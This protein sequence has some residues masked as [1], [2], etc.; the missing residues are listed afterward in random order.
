MAPRTVIGMCAGIGGLE[1]GVA[2]VLPTIPICF[3]EQDPLCTSVLARHWPDTPIWSDLETFDGLAWRGAVDLVLAGFPC[4]P[5]SS[6]AAGRNV[7]PDL[8]PAVAQ[9]I[10]A[11]EPAAVL[12]ENV[13]RHT[14]AEHDLCAM[15]FTV[16]STFVRASDVGAPHHRRRW[17]C[18][19]VHPDRDGQS[20]VT[21]HDEVDWLQGA[22]APLPDFR[23][24]PT[25]S[26][27]AAHG[28]PY[29]LAHAH[30][31]GNAVVPAQA[32]LAFVTLADP[33]LSR[34]S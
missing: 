5:F 23:A 6:A 8:W 15:G 19:A 34:L 11:V 3:V 10:A 7:E 21:L 26:L 16:T 2:S 28:L 30:A 20:V 27:R 31:L 4:Q 22:S 13:V 12:L 32:A 1:L 14:G 29:G 17:F 18:L 33:P 24:D 9:Q 25:A